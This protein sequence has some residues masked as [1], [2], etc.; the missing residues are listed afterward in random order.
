VGADFDGTVALVTGGASGIGRAAA[1]AFAQAGASVVVADIDQGLGEETVAGIRNGGGT[2]EFV[3]TDVTGEAEVRA[4]VD[5]AV[6]T[7]GGLDFAF[8]NAG[9]IAVTRPVAEITDEDVD[10]VMG[11]NFRGVLL[12][13]RHEIPRILERG[14]GAIVNTSSTAAVRGLAGWGVYAASKAAVLQLTRVA[15]AE[16]TPQGIRINAILPGPVDT[17]LFRVAADRV[18][19]W[20]ER[21]AAGTA[22]QRM[23]AP[24]EIGA[25]AVWLCSDAASFVTGLAMNVDGGALLR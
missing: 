10:H 25:A 18:D 21:A 16:Y 7:F 13:M 22:V 19:G 9:A 8:N 2:A 11:V 5:V 3:A 15:A 4:M 24:E 20:M 17:P 23:G 6:G 12:C 14:G 1:E